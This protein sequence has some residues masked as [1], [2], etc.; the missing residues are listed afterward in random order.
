MDKLFKQKDLNNPFQSFNEICKICHMKEVSPELKE[1]LIKKYGSIGKPLT[2]N[3]GLE[4]YFGIAGLDTITFYNDFVSE[5]S[6]RI[7]NDWNIANHISSE[8]FY[9]LRHTLKRWVSKSYR[10]KTNYR[11]ITLGELQ[12]MIIAKKWIQA[13]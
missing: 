7:P 5:F 8:V 9:D 10:N 11:D 4:E 2:H 3:L 12:E 13:D 1:F 6:I